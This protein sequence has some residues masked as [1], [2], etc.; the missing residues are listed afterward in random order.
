MVVSE[1]V[2]SEQSGED[3]CRADQRESVGRTQRQHDCE[4][5]EQHGRG[6]EA[7]AGARALGVVR[8]RERAVNAGADGAGKDDDVAAE[9]HL[10]I[11]SPSMSLL[12]SVQT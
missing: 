4:P 12:W 7:D 11:T 10:T 6:D 8:R 5:R 9:V 2:A 1:R 3:D